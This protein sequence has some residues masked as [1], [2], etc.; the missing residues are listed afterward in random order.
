MTQDLRRVIKAPVVRFRV[1]DL[2][3][4]DFG[5]SENNNKGTLGVPLKGSFKGSLRGSIRVL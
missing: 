5:V 4:S 2:L 3:P 1:E